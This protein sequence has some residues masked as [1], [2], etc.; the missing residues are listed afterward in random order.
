MRVESNAKTL[1]NTRDVFTKIKM[2]YNGGYD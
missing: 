2:M 1:A